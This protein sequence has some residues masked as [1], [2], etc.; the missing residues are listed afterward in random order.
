MDNNTINKDGEAVCPQCQG[1][2]T[3]KETDCPTCIGVGVIEG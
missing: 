1:T 2:G 3:Q